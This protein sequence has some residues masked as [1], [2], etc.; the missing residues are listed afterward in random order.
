MVGVAMGTVLVPE[1]TRAIRSDDRDAL[2]QA[3]SRGA[4]L[5]TALVLP[6]AWPDPAQRTDHP[7][8]VRARRFHSGGH[9]RDCTALSILALGL[10]AHVLVKALSPPFRARRHQDA[11]GSNHIRASSS[12]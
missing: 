1:L 3:E 6:A 2:M 12:R 11:A 10:P 7:R 8:A 9:H 5:A 4:E